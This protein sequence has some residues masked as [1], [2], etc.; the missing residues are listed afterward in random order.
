MPGG[1]KQTTTTTNNAPW[2]GA[3]PALSTALENAKNWF[4]A[5]IGAKVY[6]G[7]TVVPWSDRTKQAMNQIQGNATANTGGNGLS[8]QYQD[9]INQGGLNDP[10]VRAVKGLE[11]LP[12][13]GLT[14]SQ[15]NAAS[16]MQGIANDP[17]NKFQKAAL[18]NTRATAN[19]SF[20]VNANPAFQ[21]VLRQ[22]QE[23]ASDAVNSSAGAAGRYGGAV[24]QGNLASE[25]GD[26][27]G[28]MV[29]QEYNNW[30]SRRDA[31][32]QNMFNMGQTG[33]NTQMGANTG[34]ANIGQQGLANRMNRQNALYQMGQGGIQNLGT[35]YSGLNQPAQSLMQL[36]GMDEDL[37][38]RLKNDE[39]RR[40]D[41]GQNKQ[42]ENLARLNA[43][44][45]G[46]GSL[47]ST[48]TTAQPGQNP[49]LTALGY[50]TT[51][52]GLLGGMF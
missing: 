13:S 29:G 10:Q 46:A 18:A 8:G 4:N 51:G 3:Q 42:W 30:Q 23:S 35:A 34:V 41:E 5:G 49:F 7:S 1:S 27:T 47:G 15:M 24:H 36:G 33:I 31:A 2:S 9:I 50:G 26:L 38:T 25:I 17:F 16:N 32:N 52:L 40:F 37:A 12:K 19:S 6:E 11:S 20:N 43:I 22:A 39:L 48:Q 44:A 28:R 14:G 45:S 21:N